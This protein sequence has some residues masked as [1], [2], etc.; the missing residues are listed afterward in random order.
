MGFWGKA[1]KDVAPGASCT[2]TSE[3]LPPYG[4]GHTTAKAARW[5]TEKKGGERTELSRVISLFIKKCG[6]RYSVS[7]V[8]RHK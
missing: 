4:K 1:T 6:N 3:G 5:V 2:L 8:E 7:Y